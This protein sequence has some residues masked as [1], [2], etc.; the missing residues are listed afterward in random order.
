MYLMEHQLR[1][2]VQLGSCCNAAYVSWCK[3]HFGSDLASTEA[4]IGLLATAN[5]V[6]V[7]SIH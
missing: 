3:W 4:V 7:C 1:T 6:S 5:V 2:P